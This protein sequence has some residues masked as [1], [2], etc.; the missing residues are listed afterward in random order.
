MNPN[1]QLYLLAVSPGWAPWPLGAQEDK[2]WS[3]QRFWRS[4]RVGQRN[5]QQ[6][7]PQRLSE[8]KAQRS[9]PRHSHKGPP[10]TQLC[11]R[12]PLERKKPPGSPSL[13][14]SAVWVKDAQRTERL[15]S[16]P[17]H[18]NPRVEGTWAFHPQEAQLK[19]INLNWVIPGKKAGEKKWPIKTRQGHDSTNLLFSC[20]L[21]I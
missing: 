17:C 19:D 5:P 13:Y 18:T 21:F 2:Q 8:T 15:D 3:T 12:S 16:G 14:F 7:R 1:P 10:C 20:P 9:E 6:R 11:T 4:P